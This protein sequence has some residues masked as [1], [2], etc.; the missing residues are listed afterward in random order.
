MTGERGVHT[1]TS[2]LAEP[3]PDVAC[4]RN[5]G[6]TNDG[7]SIAGRP[8]PASKSLIKY[9]ATANSSGPSRPSPLISMSLLIVQR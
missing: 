1:M 8:F 9:R 2:E 6:G 7:G 3:E 5:E 4:F